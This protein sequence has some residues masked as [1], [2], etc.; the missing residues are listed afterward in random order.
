MTSDETS[1]PKRLLFIDAS[2]A[3]LYDSFRADVGSSLIEML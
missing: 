2:R 1:A 3:L